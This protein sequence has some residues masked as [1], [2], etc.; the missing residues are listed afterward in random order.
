M[1]IWKGIPGHLLSILNMVYFDF[2]NVVMDQSR[3]LALAVGLLNRRAELC[4]FL[5]LRIEG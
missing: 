2:Q 4:L 1:S 3:A 5:F